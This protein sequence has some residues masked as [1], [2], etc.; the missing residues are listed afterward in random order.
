[1]SELPT[2][3][4]VGGLDLPVLDTADGPRV[5]PAGELEPLALLVNAHLNGLL[6]ELPRELE[7]GRGV[8]GA[9]VLAVPLPDGID[10]AEAAATWERLAG[11]RLEGDPVLVGSTITPS[12]VVP[13]AVLLELLERMLDLQAAAAEHED[14]AVGAAPGATP[15]ATAPP[16]APAADQVDET[17][18]ALAR[19]LATR[20]GAP[21]RAD[22]LP[23]LERRAAEL[24]RMAAGERGVEQMAA[25]GARRRV[26]LI[27]IDVAG[28][29]RGANVDAER[30][31]L[32][33][34][35]LPTLASYLT[36]AVALLNY[37]GGETRR[38]LVP[39]AAPQPVLGAPVT[40]DWFRRT[41]SPP[42]GMSVEEWTA[43]GE[44]LLAAAT[45]LR[46]G[47]GEFYAQHEGRWYGVRWRRDDGSTPALLG[48]V[49]E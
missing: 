21:G 9:G 8:T 5:G 28:L 24:D 26:L 46:G 11:R 34:L 36:A 42:A 15:G 4:S 18:H 13:R 7:S 31:E 38:R 33:A 49:L 37:L 12:L 1:M 48:L 45:D 41:P 6:P 44:A 19:A 16:A 22:D 47:E 40:L 3:L 39:G 17:G 30:A 32:D 25:E 14:G 35:G 20:P 2:S 10:E 27:E 29:L 23:A 43:L